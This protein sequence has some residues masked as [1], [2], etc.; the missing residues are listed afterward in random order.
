MFSRGR[1]YE[2]RLEAATQAGRLLVE[3]EVD[4]GTGRV[5]HRTSQ[6]VE[7]ILELNQKLYNLED[8]GWSQSGEWRR[9]ASIPLVVAEQWMREGVNVFKRE[10]WPAVARKLND[11]EWRKLRTAPGRLSTRTDRRP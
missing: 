9:A 6:D 10:H 7:P 3:H 4:P 5:V 2:Q 1:T 11:P 8:R